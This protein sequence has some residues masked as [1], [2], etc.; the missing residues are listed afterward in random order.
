MS[1]CWGAGQGR[2][3]A[4]LQALMEVPAAAVAEARA[5]LCPPLLVACQSHPRTLP[6]HPPTHNPCRCSSCISCVA[7]R[8]WPRSWWVPLEQSSQCVTSW[9]LPARAVQRYAA[10]TPA[11]ALLPPL[12]H[13]APTIHPT[14]GCRVTLRTPTTPTS[15]WSGLQVVTSTPGP[16]GTSTPCPLRRRPWLSTGCAPRCGAGGAGWGGC[17]GWGPAGRPVQL[18]PNPLASG[19]TEPPNASIQA[20]RWC[21]TTEPQPPPF[22][23]THP[24]RSSR[25]CC[26]CWRGCTT[27]AWCIAT[28]S[29][30]TCS[31]GQ[32]VGGWV[33]RLGQLQM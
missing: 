9:T 7:R 27:G 21:T 8:V 30:R 22:T 33:A 6:T 23:T 2:A 10:R 31:W 28:S 15:S 4:C 12:S 11:V 20:R 24:A 19:L 26:A 18:V 13:P 16:L 14:P 5:W 17:L 32:T 25:R 1:C 3:R 29:P